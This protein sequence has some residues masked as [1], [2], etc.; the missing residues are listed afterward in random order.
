MAQAHQALQQLCE[1]YR[2]A[3]EE[4]TKV[5]LGSD[6]DAWQSAALA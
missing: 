2:S 6:R 4:A 1:V 5:E 3:Y